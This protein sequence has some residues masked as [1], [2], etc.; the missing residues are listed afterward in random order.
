MLSLL[1][2][3][4]L[5]DGNRVSAGSLDVWWGMDAKPP[6]AGCK[7]GGGRNDEKS[8]GCWCR[9]C[10]ID[11]ESDVPWC[12]IAN[13]ENWDERD[14]EGVQPREDNYSS[15]DHH[16]DHPGRLHTCPGLCNMFIQN[17]AEVEIYRREVCKTVCL[18]S[19][20]QIWSH[21]K[22]FTQFRDHIGLKYSPWTLFHFPRPTRSPDSF[23]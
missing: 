2:G 22:I 12:L 16:Q 5:Q 23:S 7:Y 14:G 6:V 15:T 13:D 3:R 18:P 10:D 4:Y 20:R 19:F 8:R 21:C 17:L 11:K 1:V 9:R